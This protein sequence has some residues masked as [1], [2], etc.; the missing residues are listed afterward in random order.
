MRS[1]ASTTNKP[2]AR[3]PTE[4]DDPFLD[5]SS[6]AR[7]PIGRR[8]TGASTR[9]RQTTASTDA[10]GALS[11]SDADE[12][13][14]YESVRHKSIRRGILERLQFGS[15][16]RARAPQESDEDAAEADDSQ[17]RTVQQR[18][19]HKRVDSDAVMDASGSES[20][21]P[22]R[23]PS[24]Y[25]LPSSLVM[26]PP[27]F[28]IV[29][30]DPVSGALLEGDEAFS[31]ESS[32]TPKAARNRQPS[33]KFTPVP[34]RRSTEE[35]R[36][37]PFSSPSKAASTYT[38]AAS[39]P[40]PSVPHGHG[41]PRVD[42]SVLPMSPPMVTSP[43]LESQLF[44]GSTTSLNVRVS[45]PAKGASTPRIPAHAHGG[46]AKGTEEKQHNKLRTQRSP[47]PL[48]FP[49]TASS[50]PYRGRLKKSQSPGKNVEGVHAA[51]TIVLRPHAERSDSGASTDSTE[52]E[53][54]IVS[55]SVTTMNTGH[56]GTGTGA[57]TGF[58]K[59]QG[60]GT[61]AERYLARK[62]ALSKV[63]EIV[64]RS[65]SE[66]QLAGGAFPGS[67]NRFGAVLPVVQKD[68]EGLGAGIEQSLA[69]LR[70]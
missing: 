28:R 70:G 38:T 69:A 30:E 18:R 15:L 53:Y 1:K 49:S 50:S 3:E 11:D 24:L 46:K 5:N 23:R 60:R 63:D 9:T 35:K 2:T 68:D 17:T 31:P 45:A 41:I 10:Y 67:P 57:R 48:P 12:G 39:S 59:G 32:P 58:G 47:P 7:T 27:G 34:V 56:A 61:A 42:S 19:G 55:S 37:S 14:P 62:T 8:A 16:R 33:D 29:I 13:T 54:S 51:A 4:E 21:T 25:R 43:P 65:W 44:F 22:S 40:A 64:S 36:N 26:S 20:E 6:P 52:S 66:R